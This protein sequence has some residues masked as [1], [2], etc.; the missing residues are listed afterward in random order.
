MMQERLLITGQF[1]RWKLFILTQEHAN[2]RRPDAQGACSLGV[3][4]RFCGPGAGRC[5]VDGRVPSTRR[6]GRTATNDSRHP[7]DHPP[8]PSPAVAGP[9]PSGPRR[10]RRSA[11]SGS[12]PDQGPAATAGRRALPWPHDRAPPGAANGKNQRSDCLDSLH[13]DESQRLLG[14]PAIDPELIPPIGLAGGKL[15]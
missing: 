6:A 13:L 3:P 15:R 4:S 12:A 11:G 2:T 1:H 8:A 7:T 10:D 5:R 9:R 14:S